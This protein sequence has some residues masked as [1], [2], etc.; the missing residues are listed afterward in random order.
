MML[1]A[2]ATAR[3][4]AHCLND[5]KSGAK[6]HARD[7]KPQRGG[8]NKIAC[9]QRRVRYGVTVRRVNASPAFSGAAATD[10]RTARRCGAEIRL[11]EEFAAPPMSDVGVRRESPRRNFCLGPMMLKLACAPLCSLSLRC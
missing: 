3:P 7:I 1:K 2:R 10:L 5:A 6:L 8:V 9:Y 11:A 4:L